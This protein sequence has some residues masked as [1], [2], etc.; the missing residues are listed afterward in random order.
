MTLDQVHKI[1]VATAEQIAE[2]SD[3]DPTNSDKW[4]LTDRIKNYLQDIGIEVT[5]EE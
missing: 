4:D 1:A 2:I 5:T 3:Y